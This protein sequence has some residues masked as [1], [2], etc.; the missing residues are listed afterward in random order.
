MPTPPDATAFK[1]FFVREFPYGSTP[2][3]V[4][5]ADITRALAEVVPVFNPAI[6][7]SDEYATAYLYVAAH[8]LALNIQAAG[9]LLTAP[10]SAGIDSQGRAP[11]SSVSVG[12]VSQSFEIPER[13]K[14][15]PI[16]SG[17]M[18]T[19]FG[20]RYLEMLTP[21]LVGNVAVASGWSDL[22]APTDQ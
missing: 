20:Q 12:P 7:T 11:V 5:D 15:S 19:A 14:N 18:R 8:N 10:G 2:D 17:F 22:G 4:M 9:G 13:V 21:K 6:W 1:A 3:T 16:L